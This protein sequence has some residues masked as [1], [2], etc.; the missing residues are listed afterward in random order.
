MRLR[1]AVARRIRVVALVAEGAEAALADLR[2]DGQPIEVLGHLRSPL[3]AGTSDPSTLRAE[4]ASLGARDDVDGALLILGAGG[5][6]LYPF[7]KVAGRQARP[8]NDAV[9]GPP[10]LTASL[11]VGTVVQG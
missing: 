10:D 7:G 3:A 5:G 2:L 4:L 11:P 1:P 9:A 8:A 6:H